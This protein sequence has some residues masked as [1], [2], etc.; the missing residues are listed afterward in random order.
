MKV[1]ALV[2]FEYPASGAMRD[3][4]RRHHRYDPVAPYPLERGRLVE[5]EAGQTI[6]APEDLV[7]GWLRDKLVEAFTA[8]ERQR[9]PS[10]F[11]GMFRRRRTI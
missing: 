2:G 1:R 11:S 9:R 4:I 8:S 6:E 10:P 3:A 5:V 7:K